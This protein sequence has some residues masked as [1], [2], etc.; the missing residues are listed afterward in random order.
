MKEIENKVRDNFN[1]AFEKSLSEGTQAATEAE[2]DDDDEFD[3][4]EE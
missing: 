2:E 1:T 3:D 4:D